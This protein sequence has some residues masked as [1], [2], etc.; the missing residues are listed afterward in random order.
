MD[1]IGFLIIFLV[2]FV[3]LGQ[4]LWIYLDARDRKSEFSALWALMALFSFPVTF[5]IYI[6]MSRSTCPN[7]LCD[8]CGKSV[9]DSWGYCPY[10]GK[11]FD[12][13]V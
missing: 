3:L 8:N 1:I 5:I 9:K 13:E 7:S 2:I 10:C 6:I 4:S 11:K 12:R